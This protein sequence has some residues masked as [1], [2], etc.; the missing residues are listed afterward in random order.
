VIF[1]PAPAAHD[2]LKKQAVGNLHQG[3]GTGLGVFPSV[4]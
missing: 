2:L 3:G 4:V 1:G